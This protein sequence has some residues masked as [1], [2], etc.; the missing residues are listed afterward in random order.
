M[1]FTSVSLLTCHSNLLRTIA[2]NA[3]HD[4]G[5]GLVTPSRRNFE[6]IGT[7]TFDELSNL[8][9]R[10]AFSTVSQTFTAC[11]QLVQC[12]PTDPNHDV[13]LLEEWYRVSLPCR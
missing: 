1:K 9:H 4:R 2:Q 7:L 11:C 5:K 3:R 12:I 8:R 6:E 10:G 13:N